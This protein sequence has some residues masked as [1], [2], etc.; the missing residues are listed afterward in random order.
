VKT[1]ELSEEWPAFRWCIDRNLICGWMPDRY[2]EPGASEEA[3][4][5]RAY[6]TTELAA[7]AD[8]IVTVI[9]ADD[10]SGWLWCRSSSGAAGWIPVSSLEPYS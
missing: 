4:A 8:E 2:L 1:G 5:L 10:E 3:I 7:D 6:D 9:E